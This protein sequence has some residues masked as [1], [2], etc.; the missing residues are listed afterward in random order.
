MA[1]FATSDITVTFTADAKTYQETREAKVAVQDIPGGDNFYAD[2][3]GRSPLHWSVSVLL[4]NDT[5]WGQLNAALGD[6]GSLTIETLDSHSAVLL[7]IGRPYPSS[8]GETL[9]TAE[10][11]ILDA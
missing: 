7:R 10:F 11:L 5:V 4:L 1:T 9:A 6:Q 8:N 2:R 3:G